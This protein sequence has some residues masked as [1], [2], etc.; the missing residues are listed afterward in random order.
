MNNKIKKITHT[1]L[2]NEIDIT[3]ML[4]GHSL[5]IT[6]SDNTVIQIEMFQR[7]NKPVISIRTQTSRILVLP[8][9]A[10]SIEI[11]GVES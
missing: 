5:H 8:R 2:M 6:L 4:L 10:N 11:G 9:A 3:K 7:S 1:K